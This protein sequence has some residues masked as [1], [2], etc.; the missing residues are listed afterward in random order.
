MEWL[1]D[2]LARI[3]SRHFG[4]RWGPPRFSSMAHARTAYCLLRA[5]SCP[6]GGGSELVGVLAVEQVADELF[7]R[8]PVG[9]LAVELR[10]QE[11]FADVGFDGGG[12]LAVEFERGRHLLTQWSHGMPPHKELNV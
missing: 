3:Q 6:H 8:D 10:D 5:E 12:T 11:D 7:F 1:R 2:R 4:R 9:T